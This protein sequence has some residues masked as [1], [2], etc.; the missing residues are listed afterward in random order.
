MTLLN[1]SS[2]VLFV[3]HLFELHNKLKIS[4]TGKYS[5]APG[6]RCSPPPPERATDFPSIGR[7]MT[8]SKRIQSM[9]LHSVLCYAFEKADGIVSKRR[10]RCCRSKHHPYGFAASFH[11]LSEFCL[12]DEEYDSWDVV[13]DYIFEVIPFL[14]SPSDT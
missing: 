1:I 11:S 9:D 4:S 12:Q 10:V 8:H 5:V 14:A 7:R 3:G 13:A 6:E 2:L